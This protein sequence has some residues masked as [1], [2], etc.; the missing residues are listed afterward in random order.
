M[1]YGF[2]P[3]SNQ[4]VNDAERD[5]FALSAF[6]LMGKGWTDHSLP[7]RLGMQRKWFLRCIWKKV[8]PYL[9]ELNALRELHRSGEDPPAER[10]IAPT[11]EK[12]TEPPT[13]TKPMT[14]GVKRGGPVPLSQDEHERFLLEL[15]ERI[16]AGWKPQQIAEKVGRTMD[17]MRSWRN[18]N[19]RPGRA[20]WEALRKLPALPPSP[21]PESPGALPV[22]AAD[23]LERSIPPCPR[24]P[25]DVERQQKE[26]RRE[27]RAPTR[28]GATVLDLLEEARAALSAAGVQLDVARGRLSAAHDQAIPLL[29]HG[30]NDALAEVDSLR[31][32]VSALASTLTI[33]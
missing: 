26:G 33:R 15:E 30:L 14:R 23:A 31:A 10:R 27:Q 25:Y 16:E 9:R 18:M 5:E 21:D 8:Y 1:T 7:Q 11:T 2:T 32:N 20:A 22:E 3:E 6:A 19:L 12:P 24:D 28:A 13:E 29:R 4:R 17:A